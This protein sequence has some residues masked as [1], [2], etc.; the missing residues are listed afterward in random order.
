[1]IHSSDGVER[2]AATADY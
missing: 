1:V 2:D